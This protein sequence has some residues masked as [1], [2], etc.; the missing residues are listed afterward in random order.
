MRFHKPC[1]IT[2]ISLLERASAPLRASTIASITGSLCCC[3]RKDSRIKRFRRF[4]SWDFLICFLAITKPKRAF[5]PLFRLH[6]IK[7]HGWLA[8]IGASENRAL[9]S[10]ASNRRCCLL[11]SRRED[12]EGPH[13]M[14]GAM[15]RVERK[16]WDTKHLSDWGLGHQLLTTFCAAAGDNFT[17]MAISHT[18]TET[19]STFAF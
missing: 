18:R 9:K 13:E 11:K 15:L 10:L 3:K 1:K 17:A 7:K 16:D 5:S 8:R 19:V 14:F 2:W 6:N 4:R 12:L